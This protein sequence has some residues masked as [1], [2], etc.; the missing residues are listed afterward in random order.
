[1]V[2]VSGYLAVDD[3]YFGIWSNNGYP[4]IVVSAIVPPGSSYSG[5]GDNN[6]ALTWAELR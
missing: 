2:T 3:A 4:Y 1:M 6:S 5:G